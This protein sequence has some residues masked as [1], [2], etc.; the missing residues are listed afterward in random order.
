MKR[1]DEAIERMRLVADHLVPYNYPQ[2]PPATED[3]I[4]P[5]KVSSVDVDGYCINLHFNRSCYNDHYLEA[6]Q[7]FGTHTPFLPFHLLVKIGQK[8]LGN[9]GLSLIEVP[10]EN[11]K[12]YCWTCRVDLDGKPLPPMPHAEAEKC[13]YEGF[14]Y[15]HMMPNDV[16]FY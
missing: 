4:A 14:E 11:K 6:L 12:Y 13:E 3:E 1:F 10:R 5:L 8:V 15:L 2:S 16:S 7:I 9:Y